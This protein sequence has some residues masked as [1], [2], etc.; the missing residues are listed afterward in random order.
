MRD[1]FGMLVTTYLPGRGESAEQ[2]TADRC[3]EI[4]LKAI[5]ESIDVEI[6]EAAPWQPYE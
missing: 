4:L 6:I 1:D 2:F 3:R 5:G